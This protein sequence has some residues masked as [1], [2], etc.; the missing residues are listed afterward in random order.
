MCTM[1]VYYYCLLMHVIVLQS[2]TRLRVVSSFPPGDRQESRDE[3]ACERPFA[4][5]LISRC[6]IFD[7]PLEEKRR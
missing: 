1:C 2:D 4:R 5:S 6:S 7:D 3:R